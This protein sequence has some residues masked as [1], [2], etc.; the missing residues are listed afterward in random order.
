[1]ID[2]RQIMEV[3]KGGLISETREENHII[4]NVVC[5]LV[6]IRNIIAIVQC[7]LVTLRAVLRDTE[8]DAAKVY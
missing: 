1:M 7:M 5:H 4:K 3:S 8:L 2:P 6:F